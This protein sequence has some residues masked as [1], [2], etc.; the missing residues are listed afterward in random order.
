MWSVGFS[1]GDAWTWPPKS[2]TSSKAAG[3]QVR[4][5]GCT[6]LFP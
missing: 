4:L 2:L 3:A 5:V 6:V 1:L